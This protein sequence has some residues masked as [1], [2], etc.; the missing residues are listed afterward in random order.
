M[1]FGESEWLKAV[2]PSKV[3]YVANYQVETQF[4]QKSVW[5]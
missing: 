2:V 1:S 3:I 4:Q 5:M